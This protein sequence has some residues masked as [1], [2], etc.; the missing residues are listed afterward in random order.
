MQS[1]PPESQNKLCKPYYI[2]KK[3]TEKNVCKTAWSSQQDSRKY[4][5][6]DKEERNLGKVGYK[7][8]C[9]AESFRC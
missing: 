7:V 3:K 4:V 2:K 9:V 6:C 1:H 8:G 5:V